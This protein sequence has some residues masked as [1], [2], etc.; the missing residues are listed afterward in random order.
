[1]LVCN[2]NFIIILKDDTFT[3]FQ[4]EAS[5]ESLVRNN[6]SSRHPIKVTAIS[7]SQKVTSDPYAFKL[8]A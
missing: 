8:Q 1:M 2:A 5:T 3:L 6:G 4:M 7:L